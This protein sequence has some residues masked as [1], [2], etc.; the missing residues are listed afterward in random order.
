MPD[1][2]ADCICAPM[3]DPNTRRLV[4]A[5][6]TANAIRMARIF[7]A[8]CFIKIHLFLNTQVFGISGTSCL[9][10]PGG[11]SSPG[12]I[13]GNTADRWHMAEHVAG[14]SVGQL[15]ITLARLA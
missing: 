11:N 12:N 1:A 2:S 8:L 13:Q 3:I 9:R 4:L 15:A 14:G 7:L 5:A 6:A 10:T